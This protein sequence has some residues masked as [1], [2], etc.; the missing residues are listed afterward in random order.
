MKPHFQGKI[1]VTLIALVLVSCIAGVLIGIRI[2][3]QDMQRPFNP[4]TWNDYALK[5][6]EQKLRLSNSQKE[7]IQVIIDKAVVEMKQVHLKTKQHTIQ[8]MNEMMAGIDKELT[9][10]QRII[11]ENLVPKEDEM[12]IDLLKV[13][14][15]KK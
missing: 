7:K 8:I 15:K 1:V 10:E 3:Q 2:S 14:S 11:A 9:P 5:L 13:Q 6:L 4:E 12:T